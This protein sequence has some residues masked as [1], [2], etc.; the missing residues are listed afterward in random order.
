M[1]GNKK[2]YDLIFSLGGN[3]AAAHNIL[4]RGLRKYALPFDWTYMKDEIIYDFYNS[5]KMIYSQKQID[6]V[7]LNFGCKSENIVEKDNICIYRYSRKQ[8]NYDYI[9]T[10]YEWSFLDNVELINTK[11]NRDKVMFKFLGCKI[12]ITW[13]K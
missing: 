8:N 4:Y 1:V 5:I 2:E 11:K 10:N 7:V 6:F 9:Q 3:C 12:T 13:S